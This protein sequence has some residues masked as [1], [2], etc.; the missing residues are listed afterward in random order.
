MRCQQKVHSA[1]AKCSLGEGIKSSPAEN[2]CGRRISRKHKQDFEKN[3]KSKCQP[4]NENVINLL[5]I[6]EMK[7]EITLRYQV[8]LIV[9]AKNFKSTNCW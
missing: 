3:R 9:L 8:T 4:T 7:K 2:H 1:I 6:K 5:V